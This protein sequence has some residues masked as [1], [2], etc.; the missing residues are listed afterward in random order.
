MLGNFAMPT[1]K[2]DR[3]F[4]YKSFQVVACIREEQDECY[5]YAPLAAVCKYCERETIGQDLTTSSS[6]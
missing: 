5:V 6:T 4:P 3:L 1:R 2:D